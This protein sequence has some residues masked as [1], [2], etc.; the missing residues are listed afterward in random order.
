MSY[1]DKIKQEIKAL[2]F[3]VVSEDFNRPWGG[4]FSDRRNTSSRFC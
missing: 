2:G 1:F 3:N 4:F